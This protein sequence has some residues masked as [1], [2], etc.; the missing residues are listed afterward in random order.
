MGTYFNPGNESFTKDSKSRIYVDKTGLLEKMNTL[1]GSSE[2]CLLL[3]KLQ[4]NLILKNF[5]MTCL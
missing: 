3:M 4:L 2:N 1:L 5:R